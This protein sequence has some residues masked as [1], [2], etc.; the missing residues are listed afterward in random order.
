M[1]LFQKDRVLVPID[2][3]EMSNSALADALEFV[4]SPDNLYVLHVL[5]EMSPVQPGVIWENIDDQIRKEKVHQ[6]FEE[7]FTQPKYGK[8]HFDVL[9]G[10]P[11]AEIID[12]AQDHKISLI[13]IPSHG[14]TGFNRFLMGSV[15]ER[16]IRHCH[17]PVLVLRN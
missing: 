12:Y 7:E 11:S 15:A 17:C 9:V 4:D 1:S 2:F 5:P 8:I 10:E 16:V 6:Y 13:I 14:R 3:S